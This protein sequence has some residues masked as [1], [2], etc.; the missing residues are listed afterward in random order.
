ME[1]KLPGDADLLKMV[2]RYKAMLEDIAHYKLR[3]AALGGSPVARRRAREKLG[4]KS[5]EAEELER[6]IDELR[7]M[8]MARESEI[9]RLGKPGRT[10]KGG[11][12]V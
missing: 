6:K 12:E 7:A 10:D 9:R 11:R 8:I 1:E 3:A 2:D 4:E 5:R